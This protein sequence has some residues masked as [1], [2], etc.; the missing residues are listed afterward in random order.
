MKIRRWSVDRISICMMMS[1][2]EGKMKLV[3]LAVSAEDKK[4]LDEAWSSILRDISR[5]SFLPLGFAKCISDRVFLL[6]GPGSS[7]DSVRMSREVAIL[8][9]AALSPSP[10]RD[11]LEEAIAEVIDGRVRENHKKEGDVKF[12]HGLHVNMWTYLAEFPG[13]SKK[14]A[15]IYLGVD[16]NL[17]EKLCTRH[18][19]CPA[20]MYAS[21]ISADIGNEDR[22]ACCPF[23]VPDCSKTNCLGGLYPVWRM[24]SERYK[25]FSC[26]EDLSS[27]RLRNLYLSMQSR[28]RA[29]AS[30][31]LRK[32]VKCTDEF[33]EDHK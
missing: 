17:I 7:W 21:Q 19:A 10:L 4:T 18:A 11:R 33:P 22:C 13:K 8:C 6:E 25:I 29:I 3:K 28:A 26:E 12:L 2:G 23:D 9:R 20:C 15:L 31:P 24:E 30:L 32:G 27:A 14:D 1:K 5:F 16:R